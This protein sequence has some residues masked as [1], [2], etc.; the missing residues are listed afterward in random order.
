MTRDEII[1]ELE[2]CLKATQALMPTF[3]WESVR[4]GK[5]V[6]KPMDARELLKIHQLTQATNSV[7]L[8]IHCLA[9]I[10]ASDKKEVF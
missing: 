9:S 1:A 3:S 7:H 2:R 10:P 8:A 6:R 4:S 5:H